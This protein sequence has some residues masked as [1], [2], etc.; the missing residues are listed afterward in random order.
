M[1]GLTREQLEVA[2]VVTFYMVAALTVRTLSPQYYYQE[3]YT[4]VK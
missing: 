1:L 2:G 4:I 3:A